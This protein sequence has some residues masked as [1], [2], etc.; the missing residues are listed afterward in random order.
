MLLALR[1]EG[2]L[3]FR[4]IAADSVYGNSPVFLD[5]MDACV[6]SIYLVGISSEMR[7]WLQRPD[8]QDEAYRYG[9]E[10]H[11]RRVLSPASQA[12]KSLA[13][14]AQS[15]PS[16]AWYHRTVW[17]GAKGPLPTRLPGGACPF[18]ETACPI[19]PCG[20]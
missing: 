6:G 10:A 5:A 17:K 16:H 7:C 1:A 15:L 2:V 11:T 3:P 12:P 19:A 18:A 20:W 14:L 8:T 9:G 13:A 4:Y